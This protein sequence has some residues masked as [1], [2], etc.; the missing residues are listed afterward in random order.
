LTVSVRD[1]FHLF[2]RSV[3]I[4]LTGL[5]RAA[6]RVEHLKKVD[7]RPS[8]LRPFAGNLRSGVA[9]TG[10]E[11]HCLREYRSGDP[12]RRIN[13]KASARRDELIA[14]QMEDE[15]SGDLVIVL[16][17]QGVGRRLRDRSVE[18]AASVG[19]YWLGGK[20]RVGMVV[21]GDFVEV[22]PMGMGRRQFHLLVEKLMEV[23]ESDRSTVLYVDKVW[24]R[25]FPPQ[26]LVVF[27]SPLTE[28][29]VSSTVKRLVRQGAKVLL[30]SPRE[31]REREERVERLV[32]RLDKVRRDDLLYVLGDFCRVVEW[33]IELP[34]SRSLSGVR[35]W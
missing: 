17:L 18:A 4:P 35:N 13:W 21:L 1:A 16:D 27:I 31:E 6:P 7:L 2:E 30:L 5:L 22:V 14:N 34:L 10:T 25:H 11:F 8:V 24:K 20:N 23:R 15:R 3:T 9:G 12:L 33:D 26:A 28:E 32:D 19:Y 29:G